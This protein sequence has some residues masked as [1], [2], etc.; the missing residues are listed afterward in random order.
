MSPS[1]LDIPSAAAVRA[2]YVSAIPLEHVLTGLVLPSTGLVEAGPHLNPRCEV[3]QVGRLR[4]RGWTD[5]D[6]L[7]VTP[8]LRA[9]MDRGHAIMLALPGGGPSVGGAVLRVLRA[10]ERIAATRND[11]H[12]DVLCRAARASGFQQSAASIAALRLI[13]AAV[14]DESMPAADLPELLGVLVATVTEVMREAS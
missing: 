13:E 1:H 4:S 8:A 9:A 3:H 5:L 10:A 6:R 12:L 7:R 2:S 14:V 11:G